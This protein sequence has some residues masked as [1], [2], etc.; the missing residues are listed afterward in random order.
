MLEPHDPI[1]RGTLTRMIAERGHAPTV[2][3]LAERAGVASA[4]A[5]AS[6]RRLHDARALLLHPG[7]CRPWIVHPFALSAASCWVQTERLGYWASCLYCAFGI[8][9]CLGCDAEITTRIGGEAEPVRYSIRDG[10]PPA[11]D[12]IFHL[13]I[14]PT[15]WWDN[16]IA[17]C[18]SFQPFH[19]EDD[20]E[21]WCARH[22]MDRG[23]T[24]SIAQLWEFARDWY[25]AY[26][27][28]PWRKRTAAEAR[29]LFDR[30]GL[31]SAFWQ[32]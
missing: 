11:G 29:A 3:E 1:V 2:D 7:G 25:G 19:C 23:A 14:P 31:R 22:A 15:R 18:A 12:D 24:L 16:V 28:S 5:E 20:V 4:A 8:A 26:L 13:S 17:A 30:H 9:A 21:A 27:D 10:R 6:L 32:L